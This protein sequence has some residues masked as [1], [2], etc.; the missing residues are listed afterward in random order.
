MEWTQH[1]ALISSNGQLHGF[2]TGRAG[3]GSSNLLCGSS[4]TPREPD[5]GA[6]IRV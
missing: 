3:A 2:N 1:V 4:G 5:K 6:V